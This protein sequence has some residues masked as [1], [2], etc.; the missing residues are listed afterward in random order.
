MPSAAGLDDQRKRDRARTTPKPRDRIEAHAPARARR[1]AA[2]AM[3]ESQA[4]CVARPTLVSLLHRREGSSA[5]CAIEFHATEQRPWR[6]AVAPVAF[7]RWLSRS[8]PDGAARARSADRPS[9]VAGDEADRRH[10]AHLSPAPPPR[11]EPPL[12]SWSLSAAVIS[13]SSSMCTET[14]GISCMQNPRRNASPARRA[15]GAGATSRECRGSAPRP[16]RISGDVLD[17]RRALARAQGALSLAERRLP[18]WPIGDDGRVPRLPDCFRALPPSSA[19]ARPA[20]HAP[21]PSKN[22]EAPVAL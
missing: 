18:T 13:K 6:A 1:R 8:S 15:A 11:P 5:A 3:D 10:R 19:L 20:A 2:S 17:Q 12:R 4:P 16:S 9:T 21:S 22:D 7:A 14:A